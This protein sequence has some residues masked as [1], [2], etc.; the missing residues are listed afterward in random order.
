MDD[1][2]RLVYRGR[3]LKEKISLLE[4]K[5]S[6]EV[7]HRAERAAGTFVWKKYWGREPNERDDAKEIIRLE[8]R[9]A[10]RQQQLEIIQTEQAA[11]EQAAAEQAAAKQAVEQQAEADCLAEFINI[12]TGWTK[13]SLLAHLGHHARECWSAT[14]GAHTSLLHNCLLWPERMLHLVITS[15]PPR[16][17][18]SIS[19]PGARSDTDAGLAET[20]KRALYLGFGSYMFDR[21]R[22]HLVV[23]A[24][25]ACRELPFWRSHFV[26]SHG[27]YD[28]DSHRMFD[29]WYRDC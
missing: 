8:S 13:A 15:R 18:S 17:R 7:R 10:L 2:A 4:L 29:A 11:A 19:A 20:S 23:S 27:R 14:I 6:N 5:L 1:R 21:E 28:P 22:P 16:I 25:D 26:D 9:L 24:L 3:C 12:V